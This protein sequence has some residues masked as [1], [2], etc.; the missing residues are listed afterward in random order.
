MFPKT[1]KKLRMGERVTV[2]EFNQLS[3]YYSLFEIAQFIEERFDH[4]KNV[5]ALA[6]ACNYYF[7]AN[8]PNLVILAAKKITTDLAE[9]YPK[10][11]EIII[12]IE[13]KSL[14]IRDR[15]N[16]DRTSSTND[17]KPYYEDQF[18]SNP[19]ETKL[20]EIQ[21]TAMIDNWDLYDFLKEEKR[22]KKRFN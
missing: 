13:N 6:Q 9:K 12:D 15:A 14:A 7:L 22:R 8:Q 1:V 3:S 17:S 20:E 5:K 21:R 16:E 4:T 10:E 18:K 19:E 2:D 11:I